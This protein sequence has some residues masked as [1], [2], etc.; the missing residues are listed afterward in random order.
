MISEQS[1][2]LLQKYPTPFYLFDIDIL[3]KRIEFLKSH[4]PESVALC[5]AVKA[6][7]FVSPYI[8]DIIERYEV[9]SPGEMSISAEQKISPEKM[10]ISGVY[11]TPEVIENHILSD[12]CA[13]HYTAESIEQFELIKRSAQKA[14]KKVS[15]L[16]RLTSGNQFGMNEEEIKNIVSTQKDEQSIDICGIQFFSGT[17]KTSL[18]KYKREFSHL[19]EFL[20]EL[21]A[22]CGFKAR[23]LEYGGG[24]PVYYFEGDT[25]D[26]VE[27]L[28]EFSQILNEF[29][30]DVQFTLELGRSIVASCGYYFTKAVDIKSNK[31]GN[32][33][34]MDGG[35]NHIAYFGQFM[36]M[37]HPY[38]EHY[39]KDEGEEKP[40][41]ICGSLC[42]ANDILVKDLPLKNFKLGDTL[43]FKNTGAYC[44]TE[45][46]SLF[47]SRALPSV[48]IKDKD[49]KISVARE[50]T[51]TFKL[52]Y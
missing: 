7:T 11:K 40:W 31:T 35:I 42:T 49:G 46:I 23:E 51:E 44:S 36:A 45:G 20:K 25:F 29:D 27:F 38:F 5:Y 6:N 24:F 16:L 32:Y 8:D 39:P 41:Q 14:N 2:G 15:V 18:K 43:I 33:A 22:E 9:C 17:Q 21:E 12:H 4:L 1:E 26:E 19:Q 30:F 47:L 13:G 28:N 52:N 50:Q 48:L 34:I 37:K 3:R 10:V